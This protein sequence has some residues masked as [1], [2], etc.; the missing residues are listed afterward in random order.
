[1]TDTQTPP[2][3]GMTLRDWFAGTMPMPEPL[4]VKFATEVM[5]SEFPEEIHEAI[6]WSMRAVAKLRYIYADAMIAASKESEDELRK[7]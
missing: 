4:P 7:A 6:K 1:M 2:V 5:G 3:K